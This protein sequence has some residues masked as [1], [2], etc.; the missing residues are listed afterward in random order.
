MITL[1]FFGLLSSFSIH[2]FSLSS[3]GA[4][5]IHVSIGMTIGYLF[6]LIYILTDIFTEKKIESYL[7]NFILFIY[8]M[9][10]IFNFYV[11]TRDH[12]T[13]NQLDKVIVQE[14][15]DYINEYEDKNN[16]QVR[17]IAMNYKGY[18]EKAYYNRENGINGLGMYAEWSFDSII[19]FY[20]NRKLERIELTPDLY[21]E[22][23]KNVGDSDI[24]LCIDNV[25]ICPVYIS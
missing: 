15:S 25:L 9:V 13:V 8:L 11:L 17:Y 14:I 21:D 20:S 22:Y 7:I 19:N 24:V 4:G 23:T 12:L 5:R 10:N 1:I 6:A 16:I 18:N 3:F 2:V